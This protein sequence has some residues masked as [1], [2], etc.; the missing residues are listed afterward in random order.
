[1]SC[2]LYGHI[3]HCVPIRGMSSLVNLFY[4]LFSPFISKKM[5]VFIGD[6][7]SIISIKMCHHWDI[8]LFYMYAINDSYTMVI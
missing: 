2:Q 7:P 5:C 6:F 4:G 1:M 3:L 8:L